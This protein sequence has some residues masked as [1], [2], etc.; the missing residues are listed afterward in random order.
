MHVLF[1]SRWIPYPATNGSKLRIYNLLRVLAPRHEVTLLSF[2]DRPDAD[3][4]APALRALC[5]D[6]HV[7]PWTPFDPRS[8]HALRG[9]L[10]GTP[11][12][13]VDTFSPMMA[14]RIETTLAEGRTSLVVASQ[15][16]TASYAQYFHDTPAL[17]EE[18]EL[19]VLYDRFKR[20]PTAGQRARYGLTWL[21]HRRYLYRLL[22]HFRACTVVSETER[23]LLATAV[24]NAPR[25][26]VIPNAVDGAPGAS[27][28]ARRDPNGL[29]FAG[30]LT[31]VAN[32]DAMRWFLADVFPHICREWPT[33]HLTVT[34]DPGD[35]ALEPTP[36]VTLTGLLD[37]VRGAVASASV[38]VVPIRIGGG[39]RLKILESMALGTPVVATSKGAEGLDVVSGEHLL[40]ADDPRQFA[41]HV[42]R[43]LHD[44]ALREGLAGRARELVVQRYDWAVVGPRFA[45]LV[46]NVG[47]P[48]G[49]V[50]TP[51]EGGG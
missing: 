28:T 23:R 41:D 26:E 44:R 8:G 25:I 47:R 6:I 3:Y 48:A 2:A 29:I 7:V 27:V 13:L 20:A 38:S 50:P 35:A 18:V 31:Y 19:G 37:D 30:S 32:H 24:P 42:V 43:L 9:L 15:I 14:R 4:T 40:I 12:S 21:K 46:E 51:Y 45:A 1:L 33:A 36:G 22:P 5:R 49:P 34:G 10:S 11:R 17:F 39:T 16:G